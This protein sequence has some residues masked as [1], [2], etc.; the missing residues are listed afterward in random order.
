M[1][2]SCFPFCQVVQKHKL[3]EVAYTLVKCLLIAYFIGNISAEKYQNPFTCVKLVANQM[4]VVLWGDTVYLQK[5]I[6][7]WSTT[8]KT[9]RAPQRNNNVFD[10]H[11]NNKFSWT[12]CCSIQHWQRV[13]TNVFT[14]TFS[15][16]APT[17]WNSLS[18]ST[19]SADTIGAFKSR[20]KT[21]LFAS[22][23]IT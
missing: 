11:A 22:A 3:S 2:F 12:T 13:S 17:V 1:Q 16:A 23:C 6:H 20:L 5:R 7:C 14:R 10:F 19:R 18:P 15:I 9:V 8:H 4:W 21:D